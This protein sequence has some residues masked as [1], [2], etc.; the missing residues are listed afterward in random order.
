MAMIC[1]EMHDIWD[2]YKML[3]KMG[4]ES[5]VQFDLVDRFKRYTPDF[6]SFLLHRTG[7]LYMC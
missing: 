4:L 6:R 2:T 3:T 7:L 1:K 5:A